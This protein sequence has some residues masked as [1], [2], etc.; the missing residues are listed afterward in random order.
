MADGG[1]S[2]LV[3]PLLTWLFQPSG[4]DLVPN[5]VV[6][7]ARVRQLSNFAHVK[8]PQRVSLALTDIMATKNVQDV[9]VDE[10]RVVGAALGLSAVH[11][12]FIPV[13]VLFVFDLDLV[14]ASVIVLR[15]VVLGLLAAEALVDLDE[16]AEVPLVDGEAFRS[17]LAVTSVATG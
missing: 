16:L 15:G 5:E 10:G 3:L 14:G 1:Y 9:L 4:L 8:G 7:G 12:E 11:A 2:S 6:L 17:R 13:H